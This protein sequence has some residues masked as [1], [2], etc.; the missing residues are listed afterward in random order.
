MDKYWKSE[1]P[2]LSPWDEKNYVVFPYKYP[3]VQTEKAI[4]FRVNGI[5]K[6]VFIPKRT[7]GVKRIGSNPGKVYINKTFF[8]KIL[9]EQTQT[10]EDQKNE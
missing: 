9:V 4:L 3:I 7:L 1:I 5:R 2:G 10:E 8:T 6:A